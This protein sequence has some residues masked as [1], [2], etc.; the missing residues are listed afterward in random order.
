[1]LRMR[2]RIQDSPPEHVSTVLL[3]ASF[4][5]YCT[6][7][8]GAFVISRFPSMN[9]IEVEHDPFQA[10]FKWLISKEPL[11]LE[12]TMRCLLGPGGHCRRDVT[13]ASFSDI[14]FKFHDNNNGRCQSLPPHRCILAACS[15]VFRA[16]FYKEST[17]FS[18]ITISKYTYNAF[19]KFLQL[20]LLGSF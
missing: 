13:P 6:N 11:C 18:I 9:M 1:M 19:Q 17:K 7:T 20:H 15:H 16:I 12:V 3:N 4:Y 14:Q 2:H 10:P 8:T 5:N